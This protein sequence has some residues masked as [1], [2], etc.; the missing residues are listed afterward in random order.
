MRELNLAS[1][2]KPGVDAQLKNEN[3]N[4]TRFFKFVNETELKKQTL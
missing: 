1:K 4:E 3:E 2:Q